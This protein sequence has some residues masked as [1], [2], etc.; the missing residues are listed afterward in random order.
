[1]CFPDDDV[2]HDSF[3]IPW[4]QEG[5]NYDD[6]TFDNYMILQNV[7]GRSYSAQNKI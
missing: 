7:R 2:K 3:G 1:M 4:R 6:D 5:I